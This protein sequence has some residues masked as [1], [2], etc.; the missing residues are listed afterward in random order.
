MEMPSSPIP[1]NRSWQG[2]KAADLAAMVS[3]KAADLAARALAKAADLDAKTIEKLS[4]QPAKDEAKAAA[5]AATNAAKAA[6]QEA[7]DEAKAA[8]QAATNA[9]KAAEREAKAAVQLAKGAAKAAEQEASA[10]EKASRPTRQQKNDQRWQ[11]VHQ[12]Q[13]LR[14]D[15]FERRKRER[16]GVSDALYPDLQADLARRKQNKTRSVLTDAEVTE[17]FHL[18][19]QQ[20]QPKVLIRQYR[21]AYEM[22]HGANRF[23]EDSAILARYGYVPAAQSFNQLS[24]N[25]GGWLT[26]SYVKQ[27][28]AVTGLATT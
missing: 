10:A 13:A 21:Q 20:P 1:T 12:K 3:A 5:Q 9:A 17:T 16:V 15:E 7:K 25:G 14:R 27:Q 4:A 11:K 22:G 18:L 19:S 6:E 24:R 23:I 8:A 2:Q 28:E 26:V